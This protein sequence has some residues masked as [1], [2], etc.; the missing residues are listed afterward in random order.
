MTIDPEFP[1]LDRIAACAKVIRQGG[2]VVFP[3]ETVYGI[4]ADY[5][6]EKAMNRLREV[7]RRAED[8]PFSIHIAQKGLLSNYTVLNDPR[9]YKLIDECWPG[10]LTV[11]VPARAKTKTIGIRMPQ[12]AIALMLVQ[13]SQCAVAAPSANFSGNPPP[14]TCAEA[15]RDMDGLVDIAIDG[16][17]A[18]LGVASTV[19]DFTPTHPVVVRPGAI[20]QADVDRIAG[21]KII[22]FVCT[23]NSCRSVMAEYLLRDLLKEHKNIEVCSAGTS[24][25]LRAS[26]SAETI[27]VLK[28]EGVDA[29]EHLSQPVSNILLHKADLI[30]VMTRT[31]RQQVL[32]RLPDVEKRVYLLREFA[33]EPIGAEGRFDIPD[34]MGKPAEAYE[35]CMLTIKDSLKKLVKL[36]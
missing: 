25:F 18:R 23:G 5:N 36:I 6:N 12:H 26:A 15:L 16:G 14:A 31:H 17:P 27:H 24:V 3:T 2:L 20:T 34:P 1:E 10:P 29:S 22:L 7:K 28:R 21:K 33:D 30:L 32:E 19:V 11:I 9:L 4:A 13:E 8:K 35:E